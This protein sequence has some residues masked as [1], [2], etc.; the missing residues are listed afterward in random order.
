MAKAQFKQG[1]V[2]QWTSQANG[3]TTEKKG[4]II[5][6]CRDEGIQ[7]TQKTMIEILRE[8]N[9]DLTIAD[10]RDKCR[11]GSHF[12]MLKDKYRLRFDFNWRE[13]PHYLVEV[14]QGEGCKP[15]LYHP[16]TEALSAV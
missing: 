13:N 12:Y 5:A 11:F 9:P 10:A 3:Y 16:R 7:L 6:V 8:G 14:D 1:Q 4:T 15:H 2:V